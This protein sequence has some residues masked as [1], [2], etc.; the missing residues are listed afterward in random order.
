MRLEAI[1]DEQHYPIEVPEPLLQEAEPFFAKLDA[2]MDQ[3]WQMSRHWVE[4]PNTTERCQIVADRLRDAIERHQA[5]LQLLLAGYLLSR[6][7]D[8]T[9]VQIDSQGEMSESVLIRQSTTA[10]GG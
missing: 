1:I 10:G 6:A 2:D 9:A 5:E 8:L 4:Q 7:P 3:G